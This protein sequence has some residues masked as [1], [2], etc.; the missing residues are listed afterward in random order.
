MKKIVLFLCMIFSVNAF[1][2]S[3]AAAGKEP[4]IE[5]REKALK[6]V[7]EKDFNK[8]SKEV[9][10]V[11]EEVKYLESKFKKG[12]QVSLDNAIKNKD[13]KALYEA[14]NYVLAAEVQRRLDGTITSIKHF[15]KTKVLLVKAKKYLDLLS[16]SYSSSTNEEIEKSFIEAKKAIGNPGLF[17]VGAVPANIDALKEA[18]KKLLGLIYNFDK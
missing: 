1:A 14:F 8:A 3:Y 17:G 18:N 10:K 13:E 16:P 15:Q 7:Q 12:L 5:A 2:Y 11:F 9:A 6:A 4:V